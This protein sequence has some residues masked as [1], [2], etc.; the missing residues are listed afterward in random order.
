MKILLVDTRV[1]RSTKALL[2]KVLELKHTYPVIIDLIMD[3]IDNISKEAVKI[4]QK[5]KTFSNTNEFFLEGYKQLMV[6]ILLN[7]NILLIN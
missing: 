4:I 2:E 7:F 5:L 3:S 6:S 1:N